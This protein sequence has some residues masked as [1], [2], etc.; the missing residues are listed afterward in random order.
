MH[1]GDEMGSLVTGPSP[2]RIGPDV[3]DRSAA[4]ARWC[5]RSICDCTS[6]VT[7]QLAARV[8]M[9]R[10]AAVRSS[11][12]SPPR[13]GDGQ[14]TWDPISSPGLVLLVSSWSI[15]SQTKES[16][17]ERLLQRRSPPQMVTK[18]WNSF[19]RGV[20]L[21]NILYHFRPRNFVIPLS[22][23]NHVLSVFRSI[24]QLFSPYL[25]NQRHI[26]LPCGHIVRQC[27]LD[28]SPKCM[29]KLVRIFSKRRGCNGGWVSIWVCHGTDWCG[30]TDLDRVEWPGSGRNVCVGRQR[31]GGFL[32]HCMG[33]RRTKYCC[34]WQ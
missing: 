2:C 10:P 7:D 22:T 24:M 9:L 33:T 14:A 23:K 20:P 5:M 15:F 29:S 26:V 25:G 21:E 16:W 34:P 1:P 28:N 3:G 12:P 4:G 6:R 17:Q 30:K 32:L 13:R 11:T 8:T 31:G 18:V 19:A 27:H